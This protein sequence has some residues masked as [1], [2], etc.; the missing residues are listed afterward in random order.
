MQKV[1]FLEKQ[2][3]SCIEYI[4]NVIINYMWLI[5]TITLEIDYH[6]TA[7]VKSENGGKIVVSGSHEQ[8]AFL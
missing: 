4:S 2:V 5:M 8:G 7:N 3:E 1:I 6:S